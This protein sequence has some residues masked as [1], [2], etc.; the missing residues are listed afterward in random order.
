MVPKHGCND[1]DVG[2]GVLEGGPIDLEQPVEASI[3]EPD[4]ELVRRRRLVELQLLDEHWSS[5]WS[6]A[7]AFVHSHM[8]IFVVVSGER[9]TTDIAVVSHD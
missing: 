3:I 9:S 6:F 8:S 2:V 1:V 5:G 7:F 4:F